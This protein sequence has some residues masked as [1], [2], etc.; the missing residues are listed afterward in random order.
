VHPSAVSFVLAQIVMRIEAAA[1]AGHGSPERLRIAIVR[2]WLRMI[3]LLLPSSVVMAIAG[4]NRSPFGV[5]A[6]LLQVRVQDS[7][8]EL[9]FGG[10][11]FLCGIGC[12]VR[13]RSSMQVRIRIRVRGRAPVRGRVRSC[14]CGRQGG[15]C[16]LRACA[17]WGSASLA[18]RHILRGRADL[19]VFRRQRGGSAGG[20]TAR[21]S[22]A[23]SRA[24]FS[25]MWRR[26]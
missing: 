18:G 6:V 26:V 2:S 25:M 16:L 12:P 11:G 3:N 4:A 8:A 23:A 13:V 21:T 14:D 10:A 15:R 19:S 9:G 22:Q 5:R 17:A 7:G 20:T 1:A 24:H